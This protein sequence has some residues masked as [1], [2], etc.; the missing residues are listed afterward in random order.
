MRLRGPLAQ[1][2]ATRPPLARRRQ[3][4]PPRCPYPGMAGVAQRRLEGAEGLQVLGRA[5]GDEAGAVTA[6]AEGERQGPERGSGRPVEQVGRQPGEPRAGGEQRLTGR[7]RAED[8]A[9]RP[10]GLLA[11]FVEDR[12]Q[13]RPAG[14]SKSI[15]GQPARSRGCGPAAWSGWPLAGR[16]ALAHH[17]DDDRN[18]GRPAP[19]AQAAALRGWRVPNGTSWRRDRQS[20]RPGGAIAAHKSP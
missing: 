7:A 16:S 14:P 17:S 12:G 9:Q 5:P 10:P 6:A 8:G 11:E 18:E 3:G 1:P 19:D 2:V 13:R 20:G 15:Q 4:R